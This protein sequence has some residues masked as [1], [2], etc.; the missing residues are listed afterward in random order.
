MGEG[1]IAIGSRA[2]A[3]DKGATGIGTLSYAGAAESTAFGLPAYVKDEAKG[4]TA[5]GS[6]SRVF[7][8]SSIAIGNDSEAAGTASLSVGT[9]AIS[10]GSN[11]ITIGSEVSSNANITNLDLYRKAV[12]KATGLL[13]RNTSANTQT[14]KSVEDYNFAYAT[15]DSTR[16]TYDTSDYN[17]IVKTE[18]HNQS[19]NAITIGRKS[20]ALGNN[21][22]AFG[23]GVLNEGPNSLSIGTLSRVHNNTKN[24]VVIGVGAQS[25]LDN[26][27][28]LGYRSATTYF[29]TKGSATEAD[30]TG[31]GN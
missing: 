8:E 16:V 18:T 26:S 29:Y 24:A 30:E 22:I 13:S 6:R 4:G 25:S 21:S 15:D 7:T 9:N 31:V 3:L 19:Q 17:A 27:I 10:A 1:S 23:Y 14:M 2:L 20:T 5:I 12:E 28:A 11:S